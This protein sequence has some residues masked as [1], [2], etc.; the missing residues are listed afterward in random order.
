MSRNI[1]APYPEQAVGPAFATG[2]PQP[3]GHLFILPN[4]GGPGGGA[5]QPFPI[6]GPISVPVPVPALAHLTEDKIRERLVKAIADEGIDAAARLAVQYHTYKNPTDA[7]YT[8]A[9]LLQRDGSARANLDEAYT[10]CHQDSPYARAE[11]LLAP[12]AGQAYS[13]EKNVT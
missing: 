8:V 2:Y 12:R 1:S 3:P 4:N 5:Q 13:F 6:P 11:R 10:K 9:E 7:H